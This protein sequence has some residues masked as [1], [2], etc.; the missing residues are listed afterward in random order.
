MHSN[1]IK[2]KSRIR[3]EKLENYSNPEVNL[4]LIFL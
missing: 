3:M 4:L 1:I 2:K